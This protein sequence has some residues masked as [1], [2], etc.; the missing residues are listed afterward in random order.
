[1]AHEILLVDDERLV[2]KL[3]ARGIQAA[4]YDVTIVGNG[5]EAFERI[6]ASPPA[7]VITDLHM[8]GLSGL[9][10]AEQLIKRD[11][12][13]CP[14]VLLSADD[15]TPLLRAGVAAGIDDFLVKGMPFDLM[16]DRLRFWI[17]GPLC[18][19]PAHVRAAA[20]ESFGRL[21]P[22]EPPII[23]LH[24]SIEGLVARSAS[25]IGDML[26][27]APTGFGER[28]VDR[29]RLLGVIDGVV[30]LLARS[31]ALAQLRRPEAM[32]RLVT[33]FGGQAVNALTGLIGRLDSIA[34][35]ATFRHAAGTLV[36]TPR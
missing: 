34:E 11:L 24:G 15:T 19:L 12:K 16:A 26:A 17:D 23:H 9:N 28:N 25:V 27:R 3:Y 21:G 13:P 1:M 6:V 18:G 14:I 32:L 2:A 35:D 36:L 29:L 33:R 20:L 7:L 31:N 30:G 4:G 22:A 10:L 8:P 5:E